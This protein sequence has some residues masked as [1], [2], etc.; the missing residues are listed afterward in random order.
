MRPRGRVSIRDDAVLMARAAG[1]SCAACVGGRRP[2]GCPPRRPWLGA[3]SGSVARS[4][5]VRAPPP[6]RAPRPSV[7]VPVVTSHCPPPLLC[8]RRD[9]APAERPGSRA[10]LH[11]LW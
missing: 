4:R 3:S 11:L 9:R 2:A 8:T 6:S 10:S 5:A 1:T 7:C